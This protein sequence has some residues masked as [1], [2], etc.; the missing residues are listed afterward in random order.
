MTR[1]HSALIPSLAVAASVCALALAGCSAA[2]TT[3]STAGSSTPAATAAS[4]STTGTNTTTDS[5]SIV[6]QTEVAAAFGAAV[7]PGVKG[8]ATV[9]GGVACVYYGLGVPAGTDP[10]VARVNSVRVVL[11]TGSDATSWF[12]DYKS[13][14]TKA[15]AVSGLGDQAFWDGV[16]SVS[17][18]KGDEYLRVAVVPTTGPNEAAEKSLATAALAR[19]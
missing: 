13:K 16:G 12:N 5:C 1:L 15:V 4:P 9:E 18:L 17:V 11:V 3:G 8:K 6:T 14:S 2:R 19:M 7:Q 10:D